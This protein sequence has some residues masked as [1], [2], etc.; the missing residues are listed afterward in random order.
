MF[1]GMEQTATERTAGAV[2]AEL[3][4]RKIAGHRLG[5]A[6]GWSAGTTSRRLNG[7]TPITVDELTRI[8]DFI[9]CPVGDLLP[10]RQRETAA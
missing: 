9:G 6:I 8:A 3:A 10:Q 5:A 7:Q 2:R 1:H 4:R